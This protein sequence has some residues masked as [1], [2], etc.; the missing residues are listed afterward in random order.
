MTAVSFWSQKSHKIKLKLQPRRYQ[1][2]VEADVAEPG[3]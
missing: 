1:V 3:R 2:Q